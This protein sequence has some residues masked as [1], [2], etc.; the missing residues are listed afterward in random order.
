MT[1]EAV[2]NDKY[3]S[4]AHA[5]KNTP[6]S[7]EYLSLLARKGKLHSKKIGRN[8][9]TTQESLNAYLQSQGLTVIIPKPAQQS[10]L[11]N[12]IVLAAEDM[13]AHG[14]SVSLLSDKK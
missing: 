1:N 7:Q 8:W 12:P 10:S 4:L 14:A 3:I 2:D 6:Y 11:R 13:I 5:S 9:F